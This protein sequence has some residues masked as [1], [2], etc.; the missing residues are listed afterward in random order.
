[1]LGRGCRQLKLFHLP[2]GSNSGC[3]WFFLGGMANSMSCTRKTNGNTLI[4]VKYQW[5]FN[6]MQNCEGYKLRVLFIEEGDIE[7][8]SRVSEKIFGAHTF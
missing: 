1:M 4:D 2:N 7:C 3:G 5:S 6:C 8:T